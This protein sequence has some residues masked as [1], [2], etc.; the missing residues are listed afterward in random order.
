MKKGAA[1]ILFVSVASLSTASAKSPAAKP[2][3]GV[4][5]VSSRIQPPLQFNRLS[6]EEGLPQQHVT[7]LA[8]DRAGFMWIGSQDGLTRYDGRRFR[9]YRHDRG[10]P[11]SLAANYITA[12][13]VAAD[14]K[15]W[16]GTGEAGLSVYDP[17]TDAFTSFKHAEADPSSLSADGVTTLHRD[18]SGVLWI[19]TGA[20]TLD[21][22]QPGTTKFEH[23]LQEA[24]G[25]A[26]I[27]SIA[28]DAHGKL[29]VGTKGSGLLEVT[30]ADNKVQAH[31]HQAKDPKSLAADEV[32]ALA[33]GKDGTLWV[34]TYE[35]GLDRFDPKTGTFEHYKSDE[36]SWPTLTDNRVNTLLVDASGTI[37]VG[38]HVG[39]SALDPKTGQVVRYRLDPKSEVET[40]S[41]PDY[42]TALH[43]DTGAV[44]WIGTL[45]NGIRKFH[46]SQA[47]LRYYRGGR[48]KNQPD[49]IAEAPDG[50][51]WG[52]T[53]TSGLYEYDFQKQLLNT[54][55]ALGAEG[56][57]DRVELGS[58]WIT[59]IFV[60][61]S[62]TVWFGRDALGLVKFSPKSRAHRVYRAEKE[63][64]GGPSASRIL[65]IVP[66]KDGS[67]WLATWG[68]GVNRFDP[69]KE[70]FTGFRYDEY[71]EESLG[72]DFVYT[73]LP[74]RAEKDVI[75][76]G[77]AQGGL[78]RL[79]VSTGSV[80]RFQHDPDDPRTIG[81]NTVLSM[82]QDDSG[83]LWL[84]TDGG[85]LSRFDPKSGVFERFTANDGLTSEVIYGVVMDDKGL[86]WLAT[87]GG[88]LVRF[89]PKAK[90]VVATYDKADG[91]Q[92]NEFS[93]SGYGRLKDG[94][95][96]FSG[97]NGVNLFHPDRLLTDDYPPPVAFTSLEVFDEERALP[98]PI[99]TTPDVELSY[100]D[101]VVTFQ[102]AALSYAATNKNR[103]EYTLEG[104][105]DQWLT[106]DDGSVTFTKLDGGDYVLK[107]RAINRNG[108]KS[109]KEAQL[110]IHV[111]PPPWK[112]WWAYGIYGL[113]G[114]SAVTGSPLLY[115]R[116]QRKR[117]EEIERKHR[118][119]A[120]ERDLE[121][122]GAVQT[123]FLPRN[124]LVETSEIRIVGFYRAAD[125]CSGDWW[126]VEE[127]P[128]KYLIIV[129][130]VTGHGAGPAMLTASVATAFRT[131]STL[132]EIPLDDRISRLS[133]QVLFTAQGQ[134]CMTMSALEIRP[135]TGEFV[136]ISAG[137]MPLMRVAPEKKPRTSPVQGTPLGTEP[138]SAGQIKGKLAPNERL[139]LFTDGIPESKKPNGRFVGLR[140]L[141]DIF[142][143]T[144]EMPI[145]QA[146]KYI[147]DEC[148]RITQKRPQDDDWTFVLIEYL[149]SRA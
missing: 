24:E 41:F 42:V 92:S 58:V 106:S 114:I 8:Q 45:A 145:D 27:T 4:E 60:D 59:S 2:G 88:G 10:S 46:E 91:L 140:G 34:G 115:A 90:K 1:A 68:G 87:N 128:G 129:G 142:G 51:V 32:T 141:Q 33:L 28:S 93:Q 29:F 101:S 31:K 119:E 127:P 122:S 18:R 85:G 25:S 19:G 111:D 63:G 67:L 123:G 11:S 98:K 23:V 44:I 135:A 30:L 148:E 144:I 3:P 16:V 116:R 130:D 13:D 26:E 39:V 76:V 104:F 139:L 66:A 69:V 138:F 132:G 70:K 37:W 73:L 78:N 100:K 110:E 107:V 83:V 36:E 62:N 80:K 55:L 146:A 108:V 79:E 22:L 125:K 72:S 94:T 7:A 20:G 61:S 64:D 15:I 9:N 21:R 113:L 81:H 53:Y 120:V 95:L 149:G 56:D 71:V 17:E 124:N 77:T 134:H 14:G 75:W 109:T 54:Y 96:F 48:A 137:G 5:V 131:Q 82:L 35:S 74:D 84:G 49:M 105:L 65:R 117:L 57:P 126:W 86:I 99:W 12:L 89:D 50:K 52:G 118:L 136:L 40:E 47:R 121:I 112:S 97:P 143:A 103:F 6:I 147:L 38:T 43:Q 102:F 133:E